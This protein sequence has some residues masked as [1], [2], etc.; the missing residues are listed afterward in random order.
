M[1][2]E[3]TLTVADV[4]NIVRGN[5]APDIEKLAGEIEA[6]VG[7]SGAL[8]AIGARI[9]AHY[10]QEGLRKVMTLITTAHA[11]EFSNPEAFD[12]VR[13]RWSP[14]DFR[15]MI[16]KGEIA[17]RSYFEVHWGANSK[18]KKTT[19][20]EAIA[21]HIDALVKLLQDEPDAIVGPIL[22][23]LIRRLNRG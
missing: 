2:K 12:V 17:K 11:E 5:F 16:T 23:N 10:G 21:R 9:V 4:D 8:H 6:N 1:K 15:P 20:A 13:P 18:R 19:K 7:D 14:S 22:D 3:N